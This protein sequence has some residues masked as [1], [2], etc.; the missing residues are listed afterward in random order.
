MTRYR[1]PKTNRIYYVGIYPIFDDQ[2]DSFVTFAES[3]DMTRRVSSPALQP[4][5]TRAA[6]QNDLDLYAAKHA[7]E[8]V[9]DD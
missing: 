7:M 8:L 1:D 4:R 2:A 5:S 9:K 3:A 6:A